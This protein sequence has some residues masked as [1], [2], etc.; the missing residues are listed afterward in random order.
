[1][2]ACRQVSLARPAPDQFTVLVIH[3]P[4]RQ[5]KQEGV[6]RSDMISR[7]FNKYH[8]LTTLVTHPVY[9]V[10]CSLP[11]PSGEGLG[12]AFIPL[13]EQEL[14]ATSLGPYCSLHASLDH[15]PRFIKA[16]L[17]NDSTFCS[18]FISEKGW[19]REGLLANR[20]VQ[21]DHFRGPT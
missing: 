14:P 21:I 4:R 13:L 2:A 16:A 18:P 20:R 15:V 3:V 1:M 7:F 5:H 19:A 12:N 9:K 17:G 11:Q 10:R 6:S 8:A